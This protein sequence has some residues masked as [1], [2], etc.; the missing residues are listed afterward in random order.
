[1]PSFTGL[2]TP[3]GIAELSKYLAD[4]SY[5]EG[6][7]PSA[8]DLEVFQQIT[9]APDASKAPHAARWY[10]HIASF[11]GSERA[12]WSAATGAAAA[13]A[14]AAD[15]PKKDDDDFDLFGEDDEE[16]EKEIERR[17]QEQLARAKAKA[18]AAG[19]EVVMKS[20]ILIDV[21]PWE[22]TTDMVEMEKRVR[23]I[24]MEGLEWKASKLVAVGYG[25]K[26]LS[27]SCHVVDAL[28]S[29]DDIQ[30]KIQE[31]EDLVQSTDVVTFTKL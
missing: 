4:H 16:H 5:I 14:G 11:S 13:S 6:Y 30:E 29:V 24:E 19:K 23:G 7:T 8:A 27:I 21:K 22:D 31:F 28:V 18:A 10:N 2:D 9:V 15:A 17:A 1:M 3:K 26:K 12:G 20:A 25:I